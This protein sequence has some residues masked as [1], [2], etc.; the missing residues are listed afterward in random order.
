MK[1]RLH[2]ALCAFILSAGC[3]YLSTTSRNMASYWKWSK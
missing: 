3:S 1:V 2:I